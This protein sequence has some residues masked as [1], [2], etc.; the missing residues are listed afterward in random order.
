MVE[1][2]EFHLVEEHWLVLKFLQLVIDQGGDDIQ[3]LSGLG[4]GHCLAPLLGKVPEGA[5]H[6]YPVI[7]AVILAK[8]RD[9]FV[10][11]V[12]NIHKV[13]RRFVQDNT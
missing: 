3:F 9:F 11:H 2:Y 5:S 6:F 10:L 13:F 12:T 4:V 1:A 8:N 7:L